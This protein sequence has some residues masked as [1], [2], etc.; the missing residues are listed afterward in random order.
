MQYC[1]LAIVAA[2]VAV[3]SVVV[4][5]DIIWDEQLHGDL[6]PETDPTPLNM[7]LGDSDVLGDIGGD[8]NDPLQDA[9]DAFV[10]EV[11]PGETWSQFTLVAHDPNPPN[12]TTGIVIYEGS[13]V[14]G[15]IWT[16]DLHRWYSR[17]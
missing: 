10:F 15:S 8:P 14:T 9:Y 2:I 6:R 17:F 12:Q 7:P 11:G 1:K 4:Q 13:N 3:G 16:G 5:A